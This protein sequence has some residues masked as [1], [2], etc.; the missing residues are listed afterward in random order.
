MIEREPTCL[1]DLREHGLPQALVDTLL[2]NGVA[3]VVE[4]A[5]AMRSGRLGKL[6]EEEDEVQVLQASWRWMR[7]EMAAR[8]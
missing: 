1:T 2:A 7:A 6:F 3:T 8:R 4:L 5:G